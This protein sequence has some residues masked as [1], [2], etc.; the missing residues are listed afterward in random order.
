MTMIEGSKVNDNESVDPTA[1]GDGET[2]IMAN[3]LRSKF[4][5][6]ALYVAQRQ[7]DEAPDDQSRRAWQLILAQLSD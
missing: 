1:S 4:S 7:I 5:G 6:S 2:T 3:A